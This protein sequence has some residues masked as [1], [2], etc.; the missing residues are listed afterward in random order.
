MTSTEREYAMSGQGMNGQ[1][2]NGRA[3]YSGTSLLL[4]FVGGAL[5]GAAVAYL[6]Q[7][8]NRARV[9]AL[10]KRTRENAGHLPQAV[11]EASHAAKEAFVEAYSGNGEAVAAIAPK[12]KS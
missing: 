3:G 1:A 2:T 7:V 6:A 9:R 5:S 11:R 4:M 8:E 12:H 10:A